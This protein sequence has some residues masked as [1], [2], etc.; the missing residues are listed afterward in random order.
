MNEQQPDVPR[1]YLITA[2]NPSGRGPRLRLEDPGD[3]DRTP[4]LAFSCPAA[5]AEGSIGKEIAIAWNYAKQILAARVTSPDGLA[6][7]LAMTRFCGAID[8][9]SRPYIKYIGGQWVEE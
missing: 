7:G 4:I 5:E 6:Y 1:I 3:E 9:P 2:R 8:Y